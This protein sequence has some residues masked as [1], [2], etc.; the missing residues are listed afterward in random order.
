MTV[1][2]FHADVVVAGGGLAGTFA[3]ISAARLGCKSV[4]IQDRSVLGGNASSEILIGIGGADFS[5]KGLIRYARE[6]GLMGEFALELLHRS[7]SALGSLPLR[8][9]ILWEMAKREKNLELLLNASVRD[10]ILDKDGAITAIRA[11]Q[12]TNEKE[13][14]VSGKLFVD[15]TGHGSLGALA[16]AEFRMGREARDEFDESLAPESADN[17]TMGDS[18][19][20]RAQ[21]LGRPVQFTAPEWAKKFPTDESLPFRHPELEIFDPETGEM[22]GFWWFEYG[23]MLDV[24]EGA[25]NI[26]DELMAVVYGV[27]DHMKNSGDHGV[28]DYE[29]TWVSPIIATRESRRLI[30]DYTITQND[31]RDAVAFDDRVAY[32]G[33]PI[34]IHPPEG[35]YSKE[36][37]CVQDPVAAPCSVPLRALYSKNVP[38]LLFAGR[39]ISATHVA[40][41]S[42][43]VMATC[44]VM[45]QAVGTAAALCSKYGTVPGKLGQDHIRELQQQLLDD[46]CYIVGLPKNNAGNLVADASIITSSEAALEVTGT[47]E[48]H[49]LSS[50]IAQMFPVSGSKVGK[51]GFYMVSELDHPVTIEAGLRRANTINDFS[52]RSDIATASATMCVRG[53]NTPDDQGAVWVE[54]EF[55]ADVEPGKLYWVHLPAVPGVYCAVHSSR[56]FATNRASLE[57]ADEI[58]WRSMPRGTFVFN[59]SPQSRPYGGS[60]LRT[61]INRPEKWTNCWV[62][63]PNQALPQ[64]I[65]IEFDRVRT[66]NKVSLVFDPDLDQNIYWPPPYGIL[67][68]G[69]VETMVRDYKIWIYDGSTWTKK[70]AVTGN[71]QRCRS[72]EFD[73]VAARR[74]KIDCLATYGSASARIY[75]LQ[76]FGPEE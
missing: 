32:G 72:H 65:E 50:G 57:H 19:Y 18:L 33:W 3:A 13:L 37:P 42:L 2:K 20:F 74:I 51:V 4:L 63:D 10:V 25:E 67:G 27:W 46:D 31:I 62:S 76:A 5:G 45:G 49:E 30:G 36:P 8:S 39:D 69:M 17:C 68:S 58:K 56:V 9:M 61:G 41:G 73:A 22:F 24:I 70:T 53:K 16:G 23:G 7:K 40:L 12:M 26:Y 48:W 54:F 47:D 55:N 43:R 1:K 29:L 11:S 34:D 52:S 75:E 21:N 64:S 44:A 6:T 35:M 15:C 59:L 71:Y 66:I 14:M 60:N 38:N 28:A